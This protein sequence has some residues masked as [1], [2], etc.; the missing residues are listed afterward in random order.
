M[1]LG[2]KAELGK[3]G[4]ERL[5]VAAHEVATVHNRLNTPSAIRRASD[6][7]KQ[8]AVARKRR[9]EVRVEVAEVEKCAV[10]VVQSMWDVGGE[11]GISVATLDCHHR[12]LGL[13]RTSE[14]ALIEL[15]L[16]RLLTSAERHQ[17]KCVSEDLT[18]DSQVRRSKRRKVRE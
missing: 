1:K 10:P 18:S 8:I 11:N 14:N 16:R 13:Q 3:E 4:T 6:A 5:D 2:G 7:G 12:A 17:D 15:A 9:R